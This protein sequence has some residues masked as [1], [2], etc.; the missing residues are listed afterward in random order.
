MKIGLGIKKQLTN[1]RKEWAYNKK[2]ALEKEGKIVAPVYAHT[3]WYNNQNGMMEDTRERHQALCQK[4]LDEEYWQTVM[5]IASYPAF[6]SQDEFSE[7]L[8]ECK[9]DSE[10]EALRY[11]GNVWRVDQKSG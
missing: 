8:A 3:Y 2:I 4:L 1:A 9:Q 5:E 11:F 6:I 7:H 10:T